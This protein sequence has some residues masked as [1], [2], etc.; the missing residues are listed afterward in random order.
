MPHSF[1]SC[2]AATTLSIALTVHR[3]DLE[4]KQPSPSSAAKP[5]TYVNVPPTALV[6]QFP[7]I[8]PSASYPRPSL[9]ISLLFLLASSF[10][11]S[12][13]VV[14]TTSCSGLAEASSTETVPPV[15]LVVVIVQSEF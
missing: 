7:R 10:F 1:S 4:L 3:S 9:N 8:L 11:G 6:P 15:G 12:H 5:F 13:L 14:V 2:S